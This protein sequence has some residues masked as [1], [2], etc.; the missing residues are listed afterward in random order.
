MWVSLTAEDTSSDED[1][2]S[3]DAPPFSPLSWLSTGTDDGDEGDGSDDDSMTED[4]TTPVQQQQQSVTKQD[5]PEAGDKQDP[6][7]GWSGF[8]IVGD[9]IDKNVRRSF[10]RVDRQT[11]SL[12]YF[13]SY[14]VRDR[15]SL[16]A[17]SDFPPDKPDI[18]PTTLLP[19][20]SDLASIQHDCEVKAR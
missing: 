6:S 9:N 12:H 13:H 18:N 11:Q 20:P 5:N 7:N 14:A 8:K 10:Q 16:S 1:S 4:A 15:V 19:T 3:V 17:Y 2:E